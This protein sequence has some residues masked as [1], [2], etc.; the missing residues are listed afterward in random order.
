LCVEDGF[1]NKMKIPND[2]NSYY[3]T[4]ECDAIV[5]NPIKNGLLT[6]RFFD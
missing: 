4:V 2:N 1:I 6:D 5:R 3:R